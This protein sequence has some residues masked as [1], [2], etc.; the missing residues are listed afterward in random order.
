[1]K[2]YFVEPLKIYVNGKTYIT[3]L[4][5]NAHLSELLM[6]IMGL[7]IQTKGDKGQQSKLAR[8]DNNL[9]THNLIPICF[10]NVT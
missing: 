9:R 3:E 5:A 1:V 10:V 2:A 4:D 7:Q 6:F 8:N